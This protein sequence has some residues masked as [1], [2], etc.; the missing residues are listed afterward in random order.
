MIS[1][2]VVLSWG[3]CDNIQLEATSTHSGV[4]LCSSV[5]EDGVGEQNPRVDLSVVSKVVWMK[6]TIFNQQL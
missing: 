3:L 4:R 5:Y 6:T 1:V 2:L